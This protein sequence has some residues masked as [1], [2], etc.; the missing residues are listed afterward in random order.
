MDAPP[1]NGR[2]FPLLLSGDR[3]E[4]SGRVLDVQARGVE[5]VE[6]DDRLQRRNVRGILL[7]GPDQHS[8]RIELKKLLPFVSVASAMTLPICDNEIA[9]RKNLEVGEKMGSDRRRTCNRLADFVA[10]VKDLQ[11]GGIAR[12]DNRVAR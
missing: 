8:L 9:R 6:H 11:I 3:N 10:G 12:A 1:Q 2:V 4:H 7:P 5:T